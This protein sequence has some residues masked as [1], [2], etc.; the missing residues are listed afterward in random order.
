MKLDNIIDEENTVKEPK[1]K[2]REVS[3]AKKDV[4]EGLLSL[5]KDQRFLLEAG[6]GIAILLVLIVIA[7]ML[8]IKQN[9]PDISDAAVEVPT[10]EEID[11]EAVPDSFEEDAPADEIAPDSVPEVSEAKVDA[12]DLT[13]ENKVSTVKGELPQK[14]TAGKALDYKKDTYQLPE[15]YAYWDEYQLD[16]VA[17][18]IR[19][20]RVREITAALKDSNDFYYYGAVNSKGQPHGKGLAVYAHDTYYFGEW[21]NGLRSGNGMWLRIFPDKPG[22]VNGVPGVLEHQYSGMWYNDYP[23]GEGQEH[24]EYDTTL[25]N[26]EYTILNAM[27]KFNDGYYDGDMYIMTVDSA[28]RSIDWYGTAEMG[29]FTFVENKKSS[30]GKRP[31]WKAGDG[32]ETGED[33]NY[34]WVM[35]KDNVDYGFAGLKK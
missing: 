31:I 29:S 17:D 3:R 24:I 4:K 14:Y 26:K 9:K 10:F 27:G 30:L 23:N 2:K 12:I 25:I 7:I 18:L 22:V 16:A 6:I 28:G 33:E 19:L 1:P 5:D 21:S 34:R 8:L 11:I 20:D 35:P 32:Y 13:K 15:L